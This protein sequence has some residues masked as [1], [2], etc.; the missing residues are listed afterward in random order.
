[1]PYTVSIKPKAERILAGI[2]DVRLY[3]RLRDAIG[4][5]GSDP[6]PLGS[7]KMQGEEDLYR[8]RVGDYRIVYQIRDAVLVVVVM[9]I[10]HRRDVYRQ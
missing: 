2:R 5:L 9:Q 3:R 8:V 1:M 4:G 7:L 6:R 10:G